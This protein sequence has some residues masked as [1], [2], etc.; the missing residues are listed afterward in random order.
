MSL[1]R[2]GTLAEALGEM[3]R[4]QAAAMAAMR[5]AVADQQRASDVLA[6]ATA[7]VHSAVFT[8]L[9]ARIPARFVAESLGLTVSRV[10]QMRE[11]VLRH[12]AA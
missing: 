2:A 10:Y 6:T 3:T 1:R 5:R 12:R 4:E 8:A 11:E 7:R 9:E